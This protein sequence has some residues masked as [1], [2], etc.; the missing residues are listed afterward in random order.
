MEGPCPFMDRLY[1]AMAG[2]SST[3][4]ARYAVIEA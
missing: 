3:D 2:V 1:Q 4:R